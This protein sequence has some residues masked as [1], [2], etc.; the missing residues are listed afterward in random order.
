MENGFNV[1]SRN[2]KILVVDDDAAMREV[3]EL[4]LR[5]WG[6]EVMLAEDGK[7]GEK[8]AENGNP[9]IVISDVIMPHLSGMELLRVLKSGNP[10]R[11]VILVTAEASIPQAVEAMIQGAKNYIEKPIDYTKLEALLENTEQEIDLH[12]E[13]RKLASRLENGAGFGDFVGT[14]K[15]M[16]E[17][18]DLISRISAS[19]APVLITGESGTGKELVAR[20]IHELSPRSKSAFIAVNAAAIPENLME[21]EIFGHERGAFTGATG[22]RAGCF[23]L[24]N[25]G[26][27]FL[28]EI[29]EMPPALQPKLLRVLEDRRVRRV[30]GSQEFQTDA[31]V[32]AATNMS[33]ME[34][35]EK[36]KLREDLFYRLN[37]V[38]VA[39]PPLRERISDIGLLA[40]VFL[41]QFNRKHNR[42]VESCSGETLELLKSYP[43]P[44]NVR[45]LRNVLERAVILVEGAHIEPSHLPEYVLIPTAP[46]LGD[47]IKTSG[48]VTAAQAEKELILSTLK[49]TG[50]NKTEAARRL[51]LDV[52][53]I[54][55]KLKSY[56]IK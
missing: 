20:T 45:E 17:V 53:T 35:V 2:T 29:A 44:G 12:R 15:P 32:L 6:Y 25:H 28:D 46:D 31:R 4:R 55:N 19:D 39:L 14:S 52:K 5:E 42:E 26:T 11:P 10:A 13:S 8:L 47:T 16:R 7:E 48:G 51:G 56:G 23:E 27:L 49:A 43:W 24:A 50:N 41:R 34:A 54:R 1:S 36:G 3:L 38:T 22:V 18:Y 30:G 9:D 21:S 33:P 37:V 40:Q